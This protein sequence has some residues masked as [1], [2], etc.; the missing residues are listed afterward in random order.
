MALNLANSY[1]FSSRST[2]SRLRIAVVLALVGTTQTLIGADEK[3]PAE[4]PPKIVVATPLGISPGVKSR[5]VLRGIHLDEVSAVEVM[6]AGE[7]IEAKVVDKK[8]A[9]LPPNQTSELIGDTQVEIELT[10]PANKSLDCIRLIAACAQG[11]TEPYEIPVTPADLAVADQEPNEGFAQCQ[12]LV[13]GKTVIGSIHEAK[14]V[15]V[16][17]FEAK[18]GDNL[19]FTVA[20]RKH[21]SRLDALL[22]L[23][24]ARGNLIASADDDG[25]SVDP[26]LRVKL[27]S[28]GKF[29][30]TLL[31]ANDLGDISYGYRLSFTS[32]AAAK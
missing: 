4:K 30:L 32:T 8:K 13:A 28:D 17:G 27:L 6:A 11:K 3:K 1:R 23:H 24:D 2:K 7:P 21:G 26:R 29:F 31:D 18:T 20:A 5:L 25:D 12:P 14:N 16:F 22:W 9:A 10:V 15:D 19:T